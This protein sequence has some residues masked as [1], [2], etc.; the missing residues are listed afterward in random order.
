GGDSLA[1]GSVAAVSGASSAVTAGGSGSSDTRHDITAGVTHN[2]DNIIGVEVYYDFSHEKDYT[3]HTPT[4]TLKKDLFDKN[5]TITAGFSRNMDSISGQFV[6]STKYRNTNNYFIGITQVLSPFTVAQIG[7]SR[8]ESK[9]FESEGIRLVP[10]NGV[11]ASTC[12]A[13][14]ATCV[15]EAFPSKRTRNAYLLGIN[16]YFK[17]G[18]TALFDRSSVKLTA[19]YYRDNWQIKSYMAEAEYYKYLTDETVLRLN[20]RFYDQDKAYFVKTSYT[21]TD[22]FKSASPQLEKFTSHLAGVKLTHYFRNDDNYPGLRLSAV[23]AK[24]EYYTESIHV[25]AHVLMA[26]LR[27]NF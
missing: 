22:E 20:Y 17:G 10:L 2:F 12:T 6:D 14:S 8:N 21:S 11:D 7:Y 5:T 15:D 25:N 24:Y 1:R 9:G 26:A 16:H 13:K 3:S 27:F 19:R 4:V 23:E 18:P